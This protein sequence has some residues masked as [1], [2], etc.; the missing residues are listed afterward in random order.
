MNQRDQERLFTVTVLKAFLFS[1]LIFAVTIHI[2]LYTT[3]TNGQKCAWLSFLWHPEVKWVLDTSLESL[4]SVVFETSG[5]TFQKR[6]RKFLFDLKARYP[7]YGKMSIKLF[8]EKHVRIFT[9]FDKFY[10]QIT[11]QI[12]CTCVWNNLKLFLIDSH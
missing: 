1:L 5:I 3:V 7:Q 6:S 8:S 4:L 9:T 11:C 12:L 2:F 10:F